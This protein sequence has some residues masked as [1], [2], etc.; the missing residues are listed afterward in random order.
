MATY[1]ATKMLAGT[2]PKMLPTAGG[3]NVL[4][5]IALTSALLLNDV[6]NFVQLAADAAD[7]AG[8]GPDD[9][10]MTLDSDKLDSGGSPAIKLNVGDSGSA[11]RYF[12][13]ARS[14]QTGGYAIP[15]NPAVL[16]YQPFASAFSSYPT[17][18]LALT[19]RSSPP[20]RPLR[21]P[22]RTAASG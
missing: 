17:P 5:T 6:I 7:P 14:A 8:S 3:V 1:N 10:R 22:G 21:R 15:N 16:G 20:F 13:R 11:S 2:Q 19:T 9:H 12:T 4:S 18:S